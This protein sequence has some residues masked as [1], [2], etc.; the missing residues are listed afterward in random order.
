MTRAEREDTGKHMLVVSEKLPDK[1][2]FRRLN[3]IPKAYDAVANDVIYHDTC[4]IKAKREA[5]PKTVVTENFVK[6]LS[7]LGLL[8]LIELRFSTKPQEMIEMNEINRIYKRILLENG[9][10]NEELSENYKKHLKELLKTS[11]KN[12]VFVQSTQRN[13]PENV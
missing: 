10:E 5:A 7:D 1:S 6:T 13:Q 3:S 11:L 2:F 12:L 8:N 4:W 9:M